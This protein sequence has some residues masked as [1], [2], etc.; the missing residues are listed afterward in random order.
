MDWIVPVSEAERAAGALL[1]ASANAGYA[2]MRNSGCVFLRG[3]LTPAMIDGLYREFLAQ[4]GAMDA[5]QMKAQAAKPLP[6]NFLEVGDNR[7]EIVPK[8]RGAFGDLELFANA[9]LRRFL[10]PLLGSDMRLSGFTIVVSHPGAPLQ[11]PHRDHAHL[12]T[13]PQIGRILPVYAVNVSVPLIDIDMQT[14]P[15]GLW[16]GTHMWPGEQLPPPETVTAVPFQRGDC[17][18]IDYRTLHTGMPN[19]STRVRPILYM[20][21][22]RTWFFDEVNHAGR[23]ALDMPMEKFLS[24]PETVRSMLLRAFSQAM[25]AKHLNQP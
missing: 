2:A 9:L 3:V 5:R 8:M 16:P 10:M 1:P 13:E 25:R 4:Y 22:T 24:L 11:H 21:Y 7:F 23:A 19:R 12:F 15:T 17:I 14:G 20:V 18:L 6:N